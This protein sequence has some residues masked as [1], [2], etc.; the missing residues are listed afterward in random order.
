MENTIRLQHNIM[1]SHS[2]QKIRSTE[3]YFPEHALGIMLSG[4][5]QYFTNE[6]TFVMNQG[7][8][9]L[10][11]R[12][13]LFKKLKNLG[14]HGEPIA[15][16][17][18]FLDQ[19]SLHEYA[20]EHKIVKQSTYKGPPMVNLSENVFLKGFFDSLVPYIN[21]P[22]KL[23]VN[24]ATLKTKEAIELLLQAG[25]LFQGFLFDFQEP[26]KIDLEAYMN[27]NYQYNIPLMSFAKLT[28]R[29]LSTFK[30]DFTKLFET[31][32]EK[33]LQ[34]KRLEQ[35]YY[36]ISQKHLRPS[37]VYLEVGFENLSHFSAS[38]NRKFGINASDLQTKSSLSI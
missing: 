27:H 21:N 14:P 9:C 25:D 22:Q 6:G 4:E 30:R 24:V 1:Y 10:M 12:H 2:D 32:P 35:A 11:R 3:H 36:L 19:E 16:I 18:L 34:Q 28:G 5:S 13:Q 38:F 8:I 37:E 15:L 26:Y 20:T 31:T 33:W 29:S 17:S 7:A 23:T